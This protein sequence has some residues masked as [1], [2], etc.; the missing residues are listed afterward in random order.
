MTLK[1]SILDYGMGNLY[2]IYRAIEVCGAEPILVETLDAVLKAESLIL[3]G[4]GAFADGMAGLH[5]RGLVEA[6]RTYVQSG[7][8]LLGICLGMQMLMGSSEEFGSF[9]G[10]GIIAGDVKA[11]PSKTVQGFPHKVPHIGWNNIFPLQRATWDNTILEGIPKS[12]DLYFVHS[13]TV[14]PIQDETRLAD[15]DYNGQRI[16]AVI[17]QNNVYGCQFHPEKSGTIGLK[18]LSNFINLSQLESIR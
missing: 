14:W 7:R 6:I 4:V 12:S 1:V 15:C 16:S 5:E 17:K 3:P 8:L 13:Y 18:I 11:I 9:S 10:L 2:S